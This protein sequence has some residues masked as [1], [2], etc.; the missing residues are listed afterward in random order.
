MEPIKSTTE[1][2]VPIYVSPKTTSGKDAKID[3][4]AQLAIVSGNATVTNATQEE[5]DADEQASGRKGL[6]GYIVSEDTPGTSVWKVTAD[7]DLGEGVTTIEDGGD[8]TYG[9]PQAANLG[10]GAGTPIAK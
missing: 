9:D 1:E 3:G 6:V 8:Y 4:R 2:K 5:A 7:T 10:T